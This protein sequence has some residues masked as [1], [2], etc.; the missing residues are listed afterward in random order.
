[1][2]QEESHKSIVEWLQTAN[3]Y[4][5][6]GPYQFHDGG[7]SSEQEFDEFKGNV[8]RWIPSILQSE[9]LSLLT[10]NGLTIAVEKAAATLTGEIDWEEVGEKLHEADKVNKYAKQLAKNRTGN[11][12]ANSDIKASLEDSLQ[13]ALKLM[14]GLEITQPEE[15]EQWL[16]AIESQIQNLITRILKVEKEISASI[17]INFLVSF[18]LSFTNRPA[19]RDR[20]NIFT[21]NYDRV[22]EYGCDKAGIRIID[23][24]LGIIEPTFNSTRLNLDLH[25][26]PPGIKEDPRYLHGVV[27]LT[28]L[29]GSLDWVAKAGKV[30]KA[31]IGFGAKSCQYD[32]EGN[33]MIYPNPAKDMDSVHYP[34]SELFRDFAAAIC[35]PNSTLVVYGYGFGDEHI[36]RIIKDM[37]S[38]QST[39]LL[40]IH[41]GEPDKRQGLI[42]FIDS[43]YHENQINIM[44]GNN[45]ADIKNLVY[46][47]LPSF[48][49]EDLRR[50]ASDIAQ[51][52][53]GTEENNNSNT[54]NSLDKVVPSSTN[55]DASIDGTLDNVAAPEENS[56]I[57][58]VESPA[59]SV[60]EPD[61]ESE[62]VGTVTDKQEQE[63]EN[64]H[65]SFKAPPDSGAMASG[66]G[67]GNSESA[68]AF[69][70]DS[71]D[72]LDPLNYI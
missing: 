72:K 14:T 7:T 62:E 41:Y 61:K 50:K 30:T 65:G 1:M 21:T 57:E 44:A 68:T 33:I 66:D 53:A 56:G 11:V 51:R 29:H 13:A 12:D 64:D 35:R 15:A 48:P 69:P 25:Y 10:G 42:K 60:A 55:D 47:Y 26:N 19:T 34:Y 38:I 32:S 9:H 4:C 71:G 3:N 24:F 28:K 39:H 49:L 45:L 52:T 70:K 22:I 54:E 43:N 20:L 18:L 59:N 67:S 46:D 5:R 40:I 17:D 16:K 31:P 6:L 2:T 36:N 37:L 58:A 8:Q 63:T 27:R 23:R